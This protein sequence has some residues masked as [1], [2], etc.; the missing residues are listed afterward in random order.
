M[1][2]FIL[3]LNDPQWSTGWV[4]ARKNTVVVKNH[5]FSGNRNPTIHSVAVSLKTKLF[6]QWSKN[7]IYTISKNHK[8]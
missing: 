5:T 7:V 6:N 1:A 3:K 4:G 8:Y 2:S